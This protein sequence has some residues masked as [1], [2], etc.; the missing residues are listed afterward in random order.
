M[1]DVVETAEAATPGVLPEAHVLP[2]HQ[3]HRSVVEIVDQRLHTRPRAFIDEL[4]PGDT[5]LLSGLLGSRV[6][7]YRLDRGK[8]GTHR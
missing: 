7:V 1:F 4:L 3:P 5:R 6:G 8:S 2:V